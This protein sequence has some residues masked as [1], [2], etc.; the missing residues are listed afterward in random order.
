MI[1]DGLWLTNAKTSLATQQ[2]QLK[3][4]FSSLNNDYFN[5]SNDIRPGVATQQQ[6]QQQPIWDPSYTSS[7]LLWDPY[8]NIVCEICK[9]GSD[10]H[11]M[12]LCDKC[13]KGYHMYC[14]RPIVVNIPTH[15]WICK[16]CSSNDSKGNPKQNFED[17]ITKLTQRTIQQEQQQ[18]DVND[19]DSNN[20][21]TTMKFLNLHNYRKP[22]DFRW[23]H[24]EE[25]SLFDPENAIK[26]KTILQKKVTKSR[27]TTK[28]QSLYV[29]YG[30]SPSSN[31]WV[32]PVPLPDVDLYTTSI[33]S[34]VAAMKF[35]GMK[36]YSEEL[37]YAKQEFETMNDCT[38]DN[39]QPMNKR[40]LEIFREFKY[41]LS[42]GAFPPIKIVYDEKVG[43]TVEA[44]AKM[45]RHTLVAEYIGEVTTVERSE[46]DSGSDSLM[47][48]LD[49]GNPKTSL[50]IDPSNIGN[51]ARFLSGV[52][53]R[54]FSSK[55]K[56]NV[57]TRRFE[58]DGKSRVVLFT[59][60]TVDIGDKLH[61]D[62][63]SGLQDK[64]VEDWAKNGFYDTSN[65]I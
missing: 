27:T 2:Q 32:L 16:E 25:L 10:E 50:I 24:E 22:S 48:L 57:R 1:F 47:M 33:I 43:F 5:N 6:Q 26:R 51:I 28:Y 34:I 31:E 3:V 63:N 53:N 12:L 54:C 4:P 61:Y 44:L 11:Q 7:Y 52:N 64:E 17:L 36:R 23:Y 30:Y 37:V 45:P 38:L 46:I 55:R 49:T 20:D 65:F 56:A 59:S 40:N 41:N 14:L 35:C 15:E 19:D 58:L 18:Q 39:V 60:K 42:R 29:S 9:S 21:F 8:S 13:E 62:Y